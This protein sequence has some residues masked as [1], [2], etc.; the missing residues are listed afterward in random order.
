MPNLFS[1]YDDLRLYI[2]L[3]YSNPVN[4]ELLFQNSESKR[5]SYN[6]IHN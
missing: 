2:D 5:Q 3:W 6:A 1:D 4:T